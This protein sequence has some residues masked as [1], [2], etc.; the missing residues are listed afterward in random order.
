LS[1]DG[2]APDGEV[3]D[4]K[5]ELL[6]AVELEL[7]VVESPDPVWVGNTMT[8]SLA[9]TNHGPLTANSVALQDTLSPIVSFVSAN[10]S[11][12]SCSNTGTVIICDLGVLADGDW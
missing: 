1:Y 10:S 12:G 4:Y 2:E 8:Y 5:I 6:P 11:Q 3:E 9:V 7:K